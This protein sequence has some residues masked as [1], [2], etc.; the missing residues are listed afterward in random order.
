MIKI[1]MTIFV[2]I[3]CAVGIT[4]LVEKVI[5]HWE[6]D[7]FIPLIIVLY[8]LAVITFLVMAVYSIYNYIPYL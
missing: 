7:H 3:I 4:S 1:L 2:S 5:W 6:N 8:I